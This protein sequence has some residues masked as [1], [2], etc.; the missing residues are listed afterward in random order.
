[1]ATAAQQQPKFSWDIDVP[2]TDFWKAFDDESV[3]R[4]FTSC[5]SPD[6]L[7]SLALDPT[8]SKQ[9][10]LTYLGATLTSTLSTES[11]L[12]QPRTLRDADES[13]WVNLTLARAVIDDA[14]GHYAQ[15]EALLKDMLGPYR[16][17]KRN[18]SMLSNL[19]WHYIH[20]QQWAKAEAAA[21]ECL[22]WLQGLPALGPDSPQALGCMRALALSA[23]GQRQ[24]DKA[25][26][27]VSEC[28]LSI[29]RMGAG[30]FAKYVAEEKE[31]LAEVAS[32]LGEARLADTV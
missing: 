11:Q 24:F 22:P 25:D 3:A 1:M 14:L 7:D 17:G 19:A 5:Y 32:K 16:Q 28:E 8:A 12:V 13:R 31:A 29:D 26:A 6:Q 20:A 30:N 18:M 15:A 27:W 9:D 21:E 4:C 23:I 2:Q 10:K